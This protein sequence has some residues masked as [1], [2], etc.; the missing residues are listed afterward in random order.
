[1]HAKKEVFQT[2]IGKILMN[3]ELGQR[4]V[5]CPEEA[6]KD[7]KALINVPDEVKIVFLPAGDSDTP[8]GGSVIIELPPPDLPRALSTT[9]LMEHFLCTYNPW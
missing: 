5:D 2:I 9:D 8:G 4:Y 7:I 3:P 1:M 6:R